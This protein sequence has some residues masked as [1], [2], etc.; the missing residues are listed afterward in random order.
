MNHAS[1]RRAR[2][3]QRGTYHQARDGRSNAKPRIDRRPGH[4]R[5]PYTSLSSYTPVWCVSRS[6]ALNMW[7]D[8]VQQRHA[9]DSEQ[10]DEDDIGR[11][12]ARW[13]ERCSRNQDMFD[14]LRQV[15]SSIVWRGSIHQLNAPTLRHSLDRSAFRGSLSRTVSAICN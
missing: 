6:L 11:Y 7:G 15:Y 5:Y 13:C 10:I 4:W 14:R 8:H 3:L 1:L 12:R 2:V 9:F